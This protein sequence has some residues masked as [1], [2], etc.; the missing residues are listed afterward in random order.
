MSHMKRNLRNTLNSEQ[1][2][3]Y[4]VKASALYNSYCKMYLN[5]SKV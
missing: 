5:A 4:N 2:N 3:M 1:K